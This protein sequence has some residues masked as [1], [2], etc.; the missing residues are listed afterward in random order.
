MYNLLLKHNG[1]AVSETNPDRWWKLDTPSNPKA[2]PQRRW[3][4]TH[5]VALNC[6]PS[7]EANNYPEQLQLKAVIEKQS[8]LQLVK[9]MGVIFH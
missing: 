7:G 9:R 3:Y 5:M 6:I 8:Q 1:T 2:D 4:C